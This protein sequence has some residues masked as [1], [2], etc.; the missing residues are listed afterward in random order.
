MQPLQVEVPTDVLAPPV[1]HPEAHIKATLKIT[2]G[3]VVLIVRLCEL[4]PASTCDQQKITRQSV[5]GHQVGPC[6][7]HVEDCIV[8]CDCCLGVCRP[9]SGATNHAISYVFCSASLYLT[10]VASQTSRPA[11]HTRCLN[12]QQAMTAKRSRWWRTL[13]TTT[14]HDQLS[15]IGLPVLCIIGIINMD[16]TSSQHDRQLNDRVV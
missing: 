6:S 1:H 14:T 9:T 4:S 12:S 3:T 15:T 10:S 8:S 5:S 13:P 7:L 2:L 16:A 11:F